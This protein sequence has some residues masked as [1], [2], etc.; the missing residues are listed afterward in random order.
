MATDETS[1][2]DRMTAY[3]IDQRI[4]GVETLAPDLYDTSYGS[5]ERATAPSEECR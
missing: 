5:L 3:E 4:P 1:S 2:L